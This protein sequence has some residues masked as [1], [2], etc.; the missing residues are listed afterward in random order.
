MS[1]I[2]GRFSNIAAVAL[3]WNTSHLVVP[4]ITSLSRRECPSG[5]QQKDSPT[6]EWSARHE[7]YP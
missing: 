4:I 5:R 6:P 1:A 2:L 3:W 7:D